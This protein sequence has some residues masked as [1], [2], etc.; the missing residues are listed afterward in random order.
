MKLTGPARAI[1]PGR[2]D[3]NTYTNRPVVCLVQAGRKCGGR[4]IWAIKSG[5]QTTIGADEDF[6]A[7]L[8]DGISFD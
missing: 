1:R 6:A 5:Y 8:I 2:G 7:G 3:E 4:N